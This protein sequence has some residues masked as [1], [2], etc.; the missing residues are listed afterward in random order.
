MKNWKLELE[1][2]QKITFMCHLIIKI[3]K[4]L[5]TIKTSKA[6]RKEHM[7]TVLVEQGERESP[8]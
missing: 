6:D 7:Q 3:N 2:E 4:K 5:V 8:T 1:Q